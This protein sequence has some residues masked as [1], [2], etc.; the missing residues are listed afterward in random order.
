MQ[1]L[2]CQKEIDNDSKFCEFCRAR[3]ENVNRIS[4][5]K[6]REV[7]FNKKAFYFW[8][9]FIATILLIIAIPEVARHRSNY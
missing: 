2:K 6:F 4:K 9:F 8:L 3:I 5:L 1:C 7:L